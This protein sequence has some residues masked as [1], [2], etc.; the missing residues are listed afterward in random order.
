MN[1]CAA[2]CVH[3]SHALLHGQS[4]YVLLQMVCCCAVLICI[5]TTERH[6]PCMCLWPR[7]CRKVL[8]QLLK[9]LGFGSQSYQQHGKWDR[10]FI[11][12]GHKRHVVAGQP[13]LPG[14]GWLWVA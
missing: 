2:R 8:F 14:I 7:S 1:L 12:L 10:Q 13:S 6:N 9:G 4:M 11:K 5:F 3:S